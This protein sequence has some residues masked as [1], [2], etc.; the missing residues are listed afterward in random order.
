MDNVFKIRTPLNVAL[1]I[2]GALMMTKPCVQARPNIVFMLIDDMDKSELGAF[3]S[4]YP[5]LTTNLN[6]LAKDGIIFREAYVNTTVCTPSRYSCI[7]G[8]H[9]GRST[10]PPYLVEC[11][12][13]NQG[14]PEFNV[15]MIPTEFN[16]GRALKQ[17]GYVSGWV[18]KF[19]L[20][21]SQTNTYTSKV[22]GATVPQEQYVDELYSLAA[23]G[24]AALSGTA[25]QTFLTNT[26]TAYFKEIEALM[27]NRIVNE[28]G[29][30]TAANIYESNVAAPFDQHNAD[31]TV[32]AALDF[33]DA[34]TS[35]GAPPFYLHFCPTLIHGTSGS[36]NKGLDYPNYTGAGWINTPV[37][38][39]GYMLSRTAIRARVTGMGLKA[40]TYAGY[41][42]L[43][44][45]VGAIMKKLNE[46]GV[47]TN[48]VFIFMPDH[49]S[50]C[51]SSLFN[52]DATE[53]PLIIRYPAVMTN[54]NVNKGKICY[55]LVQ[56]IDI[57]PT[58]LELAGVSI[59]SGLD[60]KSF[61]RYLTNPADP[62]NIHDHLYFEL[63]SARSILKDNYRLIVNRY[64]DE[65]RAMMLN[66]ISRGNYT[67]NTTTGTDRLTTDYSYLGSHAGIS[68]R[69]M[70][71]NPEYLAFEQLYDEGPLGNR[72]TNA[73]M[74]V[75]TNM[76]NLLATPPLS[77]AASA[78]LSNLVTQLEA[79]AQYFNTT[80]GQTRTYGAFNTGS[81]STNDIAE[82]ENY[83]T[84][85]LY[86]SN[87]L[88]DYSKKNSLK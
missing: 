68:G 72:I 81:T 73:E 14:S 42:W 18:G 47:A 86:W 10:Y 60:G 38:V 87:T 55:K 41:V 54:T 35:T 29:Y 63:G 84:N 33:I 31:W 21:F 27:E 12:T 71:Y 64:P 83:P 13:N 53:V 28:L 2:A 22:N 77:P 56:N 4:Q 57:A 74:K 67:T 65:R 48:T 9:P 26:A 61:S 82:P 17:S 32:K 45:A 36:W 3:D 50:G 59:P 44:E 70:Q 52:R 23:D 80:D 79:D 46:K 58:L 16:L 40:N 78:A 43:D 62:T 76:K 34:H 6:Q 1:G 37:D 11:P 15:G 8:R 66:Q 30:S 51:K 75:G 85:V 19:H 7:T 25:A 69:G 24:Y 20:G 39:S 49:G 5:T 88:Y